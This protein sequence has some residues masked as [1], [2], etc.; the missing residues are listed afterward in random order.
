M[1]ELTHC[2]LSHFVLYFQSSMQD[3]KCHSGAKPEVSFFYF[4]NSYLIESTTPLLLSTGR[5]KNLTSP[6]KKLHL[7]YSLDLKHNILWKTGHLHTASAGIGLTKVSA[8]HL[9][10]GTEVIHFLYK[11][12]GL[13]HFIHG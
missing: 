5:H 7:R 13:Y 2:I 10:Y 6:Q 4:I 1:T 8:V 12:G 3:L 9:V 11:H